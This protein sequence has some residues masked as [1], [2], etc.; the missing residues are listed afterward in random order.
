MWHECSG[1]QSSASGLA[2]ATRTC[3]HASSVF[4]LGE[5]IIV[6]SHIALLPWNPGLDRFYKFHSGMAIQV[7]WFM[8]AMS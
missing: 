2:G 3:S 4:E 5:I 7:E 6:I 1:A 8:K